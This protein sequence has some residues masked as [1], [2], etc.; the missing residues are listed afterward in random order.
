VEIPETRYAKSRDLNIAWSV[1]GAGP[2]D[3]LHCSNWTSHVEAFWDWA[4]FARTIRRLATLGRVISFDLPGNGLS[5]PVSLDQLPT[6]E[7]WMECVRV[8]MDAAGSERAVLFASGAAGGLAIPFAATHPDRVS[9]L[10]LQDSFARLRRADD[11]PFGLPEAGIETGMRWFLDRWGTGRQLELTAP[12]LA[13][14]A[15]ELNLMGRAER[16]SASPGVADAFFR[17]ITDIDVRN[18][19]PAVHVPT[20]VVHRAGDRWIRPQH[21]RYL[22]DQVAGARYAEVPGDSSHACYGDTEAVINEIRSF[23]EVLPE[24]SDV[25][26]VLATILFT[27]I[28]DSTKR[29]AEM[30]DRK[31]RE[32]LDRHD[33]VVRDHIERF[34]GRQIKTTGDGVLATF[35]GAAR[36]VRCSVSIREAMRSLGIQIRS[37]VHSGEIELRGED[38]G[39]IAVHAAARVAALA[40]SGEILASQTVKDLTVG[41]GLT[42]E[43]RGSHAL[44]GV[45]GEWPLYAV[46]A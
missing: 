6:I 45:P 29:A 26:R 15:Y 31:W 30:G 27:D 5:D 17:M 20:L 19:L 2:H 13:N 10:V 34:R 43:E 38:V 16:Y 3:I 35:D 18:V 40:G 23:L 39:G 37:G 12:S 24:Q 28:V 1:G 14:D 32:M 44:K 7:Q 36:A 25:D 33:A 8:V 41:S 11:Y 46:R 9:G 4:P 22:A 42:F 21:G